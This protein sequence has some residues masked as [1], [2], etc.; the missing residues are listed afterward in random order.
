MKG[1][2]ESEVIP[3]MAAGSLR[4]DMA[5]RS[6]ESEASKDHK[7]PARADNQRMDVN[8][9]EIASN[10]S[11]ALFEEEESAEMQRI[12]CKQFVHRH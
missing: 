11:E 3:E 4:F 2:E 1:G 7:T 9:K 12:P 6:D 8:E 5:V 10:Y